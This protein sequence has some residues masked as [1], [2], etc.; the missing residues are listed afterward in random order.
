MKLPTTLTVVALPLASLDNM[1]Q[2]ELFLYALYHPKKPG[3]VPYQ[4]TVAGIMQETTCNTDGGGI[5]LGLFG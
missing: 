4:V 5:C 3:Q 2:I 1:T